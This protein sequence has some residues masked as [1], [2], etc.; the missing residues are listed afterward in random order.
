MLNRLDLR[1]ATG[2]LRSRLP[3]PSGGGAA[4]PLAAVQEILADVRRRGDAAVLE[5]T[6]RFDGVELD[7]LRVPAHEVQAAFAAIDPAV[8]E[9][10]AVAAA[11]IEDFHRT[12]VEPD[13]T[14]ERDGIVVQALHRPVDRA[15]CYVPGG[16][17]R[18]PSTVLMTAVP[19]RVA[20]VDQVVLCV[21][22]D[23]TGH[24]PSVTLAAAALAGVDEVYA[25]GGAQAVGA[26]AY[27]TESMAPVDVI[28]GPGNVY[29][30]LAKREV[31]G[32]V[33]VPSSFAGPSEIVVI[34][35]DAAP[36]ASAAV[37]VILQAEHGPGG[38]AWLVTWSPDAA[39]AIDAEIAHQ[40][41]ASPRRGDIESTFAEGGYV[42]LVD[43][44]E[45]AVEVSNLIAPE[46]LELMTA[47]PAALVPLVR[48]AGAVF[49]GPWAPASVGDYLAGPNHV[50]PTDGTAR[51]A[52]ALTV[53]RL[54]EGAA[55]GDPRRG[56]ARPGGAARGR[57]G[58]G[59]GAGRPRRLGP[60]AFPRRPPRHRAGR[61]RPMT[62][63]RPQPR[64]DVALMDGYH[65]PQ[66]D[67]EVRLNTN[68]SPVEPPAA[69][70][71]AVADAARTIRWNRYPDRAATD[72]R[73][74]IGE[75][76][77]VGPEQVFAANG[78]NE[79]LQTLSLTY[80]GAGR[81]VAVFEPT[82]A[83]H[84]HIARITGTGVA[85]GERAADFTL[86]L[87]EVRRVLAEADPAV[88][89]LCSPNNPTG[90]VETRD[91]VEQVLGLAPG[92]L[93]VDEA[94][95][96]FAPWSAL[97]LVDEDRPLVVT[98]TYSKTWSMAGARLGYLIGPS[99]L[100]AE[101]EKVVLPYHLDAFTQVAGRLALEHRAEMD[102]RVAGL[103]EE[104]GRLVAGL[105]DLD[106]E[107]WPSGANFVLF[108][109]R[110]RD[111]GAVWQELLDRSV[112]VRN[113]SSWPRLEGCLRVTV[114]TETEDDRFLAAL[115][116]VLA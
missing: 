108:R 2:D 27:G 57:A 20:G 68:E 105:C 85:V 80:G 42:V 55:R 4:E 101:L 31:A 88:T 49:C 77:D 35:D 97:E 37:D 39:D 114:G 53:A 102:A 43:G 106:V 32:V 58:R 60:A 90:L 19:A 107:V 23:R 94:Y 50:L 45:Q 36:P 40:V 75:L 104:R 86:D 5:L 82:Y 91:T 18:Y 47:D 87:D 51:F 7:Q 38:L 10:L 73:R 98:R 63:T 79:V 110:S 56:V 67:V 48:H 9:A 103:V 54:P 21:P 15:G 14:Y 70:L 76:H 61:G 11:G 116:E 41:E 16:R 6:A 83:L 59:R 62:T 109:P 12:Q 66:V 74:A 112:L 46:H 1:G 65:S 28:V 52:S 29:V 33:G 99:W 78:S 8:R 92:L 64:A 22:P 89:Y 72:L 44:P 113:C 30:A 95:G 13:R 25:C 26:M 24:V 3:R 115:Q 100:V 17:A 96:Q 69:W 84:S 93:V 71:D 34:A 81:C 111:G